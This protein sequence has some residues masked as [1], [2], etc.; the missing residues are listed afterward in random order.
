MTRLIPRQRTDGKFARII[1]ENRVVGRF[2]IW[3]A[4]WWDEEK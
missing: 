4:D 2:W 1:F 3:R